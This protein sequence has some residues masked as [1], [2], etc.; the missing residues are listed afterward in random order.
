MSG[1]ETVGE[2]S[3][4]SFAIMEARI[5]LRLM[6]ELPWLVVS[7]HLAEVAKSNEIE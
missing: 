1:D 2:H 3:S 4:M 7:K 5:Q 6:C